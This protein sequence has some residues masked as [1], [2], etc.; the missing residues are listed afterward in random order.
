MI[1]IISLINKSFLLG[2]YIYR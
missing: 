2:A 1:C